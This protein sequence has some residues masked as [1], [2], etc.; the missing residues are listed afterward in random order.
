MLK[1]KIEPMTLE[2]SSNSYDQPH[3]LSSLIA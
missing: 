2:E 3:F 1:Y